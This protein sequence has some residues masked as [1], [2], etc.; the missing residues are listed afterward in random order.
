MK[1][2][3]LQWFFVV[4]G[5]CAALVGGIFVNA[6]YEFLK[7]QV[8][9]TWILFSSFIILVFFLNFFDYIFENLPEVRK[10]KQTF[11][12]LFSNSIK[13]VFSKK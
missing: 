12:R 4:L 6:L 3:K 11:W 10:D 2:I 8:S 5:L 7:T 9:L 13:A 1:N